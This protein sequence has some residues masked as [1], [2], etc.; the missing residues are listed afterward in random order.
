[1]LFSKLEE[2]YVSFGRGFRDKKTLLEE[3]KYVEEVT[4][5]NWI[6]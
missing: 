5:S 1:M 3:K 4:G 2:T 6:L